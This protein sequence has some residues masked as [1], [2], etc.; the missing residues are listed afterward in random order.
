MGRSTLTSSSRL[1]QALERATEYVTSRQC[2]NG[3]FCY[4]RYADLEEPNLHDTYYA[5][6][7]CEL[8]HSEVPYPE[9]VVA[10]LRSMRLA[11][12]QSSYLYC[13]GFTARRLGNL[14]LLDQVFLE[15][16]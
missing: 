2:R 6:A 13:S 7:A 12:R 9:R 14:D 1:K 11:G 5:V 4:Y 3:G 8:L 15:K 10:Y 16:V